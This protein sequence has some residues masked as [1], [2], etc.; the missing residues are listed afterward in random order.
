MKEVVYFQDIKRQLELTLAAVFGREFS[1][2]LSDG[3]PKLEAH[4]LYLPNS[5]EAD[6]IKAA[7]DKFLICAIHLA[8]HQVYSTPFEAKG[9]NNRQKVLIGVVEDARVEALVK[10]DFP[11]IGRIISQVLS[12]DH[13]FSTHFDD[14]AFEVAQA[15]HGQKSVGDFSPKYL[16]MFHESDL[17]DVETSRKIGLS[18]AND[19]GQLRISMN[20]RQTFML[21]DYRDDNSFLWK[22]E[23]AIS[24]SD[25]EPEEVDEVHSSGISFEEVEHGRQV[26]TQSIG[27]L[28]TDFAIEANEQGYDELTSDSIILDDVLSYPEW[29]YRIGHLKKDWCKLHEMHFEPADAALDVGASGV[30]LAKRLYQTISRFQFEHQRMKRQKEG[31][32]LDIDA[33][34][35]YSVQLRSGQVG[36]EQNIY[37]HRTRQSHNDFSVLVL[38]DLSES[39]NQKLADTDQSVLSLTLESSQVLTQL[40]DLLGHDY[41]VDGFN[42]DG[43]HQVNYQHLKTFEDKKSI[44]VDGVKAQYST[45]LG[46]ALR[47]AYGEVSR[48]KAAHPL[49]LLI[50]DGKPSD[51]DVYDGRYLTEDAGYAVKEIEASGCKVFCLSLDKDS[52]DY[53]QQIFRKNH[54]EV[55]DHPRKLSEFLVG[56]YLKVFKSFL[57]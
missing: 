52:D 2:L 51:I 24:V 26:A 55:L 34:V 30:F 3:L 36:S 4:S 15:F 9:L 20:E 57:K 1:L 50:T 12:E 11:G 18:M 46:A 10:A 14:L 35:D 22:E 28:S 21:L 16:K 53:L 19:I 49:I 48:Q 25:Q 54:F 23:Q 44:V 31:N 38:L 41:Q 29:D 32:D 39:M 40:L 56:F 8:A 43:R 5:F 6:S 7:Y 45:R 27:A 47:H 37:I 33:L 42:S 13:I 17:A